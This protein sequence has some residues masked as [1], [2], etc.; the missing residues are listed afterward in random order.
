LWFLGRQHI[1]LMVAILSGE[2]P[3]DHHQ[4]A[5]FRAGVPLPPAAAR[6][7]EIHIAEGARHISFATEFLRVH[8]PR[9]DPMR[10]QVVAAL[11]PI[12][13][14]AGA[15]LI[16]RLPGSVAR[17]L[18]IPREVVKEAFFDSTAS[19]KILGDFFRDMRALAIET[20]L[21]TPVSRRLWK[22]VKIDGQPSRFRGEPVRDVLIVG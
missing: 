17:D 20:G 4:K 11:F 19:R 21:M 10:R 22:L 12:I 9:L 3:I 7:M 18:E 5:L 16:A 2:E 1:L 15:D 8:L 14:R 6:V 13:M